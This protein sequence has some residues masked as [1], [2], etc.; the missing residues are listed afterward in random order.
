MD[1]AFREEKIIQDDNDFIYQ[2]EDCPLPVHGQL[3]TGLNAAS[4]REHLQQPRER[5]V[6]SGLLKRRVLFTVHVDLKISVRDNNHFLLA[7]ALVDSREAA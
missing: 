6:F 1:A 4:Q 5:S 7:F 2:A 3:L